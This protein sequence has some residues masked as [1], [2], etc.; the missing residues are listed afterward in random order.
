MKTLHYSN[1]FPRPE[2]EGPGV[3]VKNEYANSTVS[4][5]SNQNY[6]PAS[7]SAALTL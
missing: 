7:P 5:I 4:L 2:G 1:F 6:F 3:R